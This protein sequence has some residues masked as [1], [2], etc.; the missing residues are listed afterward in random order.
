MGQEGNIDWAQLTMLREEVGPD[1]IGEVAEAFLEE[2]EEVIERLAAAPDP[3]R[4]RADMHFIKGSALSLGF[5]PF[6]VLCAEAEAAAA[7]G[8]ASEVDLAE[9]FACYDRSKAEF[10]AGLERL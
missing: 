5:A 7:A 10:L 6:A 4:L 1:A 9:I 3:A 2:V 8:R